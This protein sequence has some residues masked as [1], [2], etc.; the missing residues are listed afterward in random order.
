MEISST[1]SS[2]YSV[3]TERATQARTRQ[4]EQDQEPQAA[5]AQ[6]AQAQPT[7]PQPQSANNVQTTQAVSETEKAAAARQEAEQNR[8][9]VNTSGQL[10]GTRVN[11]TA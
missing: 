10:V 8:P 7:P 9:V 1:T 3:I 5:Q 4:V 11:T 6:A 2:L